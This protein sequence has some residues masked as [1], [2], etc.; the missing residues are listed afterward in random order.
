MCSS[1]FRPGPPDLALRPCASWSGHHSRPS[2]PGPLAWPSVHGQPSSPPP[3]CFVIYDCVSLHIPSGP[4]SLPW[5]RPLLQ[6][7]LA[8]PNLPFPSSP[9]ARW[10]LS[11]RPSGPVLRPWPLGLAI[12]PSPSGSLP[13][14]V[15]LA[16]AL[17]PSGHVL[18]E[19]STWPSSP[20][21]LALALRPWTY[22]SGH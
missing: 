14:T 13:M 9:V 7:F 18:F 17:R 19:F 2:R 21:P 4:V 15:F 20:G 10:P 3:P 16:T 6:T 11:S 22:W 12:W 8:L 5:P 1:D